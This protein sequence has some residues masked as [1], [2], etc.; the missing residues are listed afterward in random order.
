MLIRFI[1]SHVYQSFSES[2]SR[3]GLPLRCVFSGGREEIEKITKMIGRAHVRN[4]IPSGDCIARF[5]QVCKYRL[6]RGDDIGQYVRRV[7]NHGRFVMA[8]TVRNQV[9]KVDGKPVGADAFITFLTV[10]GKLEE[11]VGWYNKEG[12]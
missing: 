5:S 8:D 12:Q 7:G 1:L 11:W 6:Q 2:S 9:A 3:R 10:G 4:G